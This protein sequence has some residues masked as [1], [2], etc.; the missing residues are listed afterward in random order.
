MTVISDS[1]A[2]PTFLMSR[3]IKIG[4]DS[5]LETKSFGESMAF[6]WLAEEYAKVAS[7]GL[8]NELEKDMN[9]LIHVQEAAR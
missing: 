4:F 1:Q 5:C 9:P 7:Q 6:E 3:M 8:F 2:L